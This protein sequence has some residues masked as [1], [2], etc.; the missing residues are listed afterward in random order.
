MASRRSPAE[1]ATPSRDLR[2]IADELRLPVRRQDGRE[3]PIG[4]RALQTRSKL[5]E[6]AT[7][8]FAERGYLSTSL[9]DIAQAAG[10]SLAT[11]YQYFS[12][13]S[14]VVAALAGEGAVRMLSASIETWD[15]GT[16]RI[17]L[18][19]AVRSLVA[20]FHDNRALLAILRVGSHTDPRLDELWRD[21]VGHHQARFASSLAVG[22]K[23]DLIRA[24]L[25][26]EAVARALT[27]T[28]FEHCHD[29]FI[30]DPGPTQPG[31]DETTDVLTSLWADT[32]GLV[33]MTER[34]RQIAGPVRV[35]RPGKADDRPR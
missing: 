30:F 10:V 26:P 1:N 17:G 20:A 12:D 23:A 15:P 18:R 35:A 8:M 6:I 28:I 5:L 32:I 25:A 33:E 24:D 22:I 31:V 13:R 14:D 4:T 19:R 27:L 16:G 11:V 29:V 2:E 7:G 34:R 3:T 21:L 9:G